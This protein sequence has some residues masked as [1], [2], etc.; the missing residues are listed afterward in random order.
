MYLSCQIVF[1]LKPKVGMTFE[2]LKAVEDF[3]KSCAH[4]SG[5]GVRIGQEKKLENDVV[6]TK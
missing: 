2:G 3:D 1:L 6:R 5:F 4:Q